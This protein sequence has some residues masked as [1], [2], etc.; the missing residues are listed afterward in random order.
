MF[1]YS[2][3]TGTV[4]DTGYTGVQGATGQLRI[5]LYIKR[6]QVKPHVEPLSRNDSVLVVHKRVYQQAV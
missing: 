4:G 6:Y 5:G 1:I 2:G 3:A